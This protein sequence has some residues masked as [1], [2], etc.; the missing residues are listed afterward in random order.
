[1]AA[2]KAA[3]GVVFDSLMTLRLERSPAGRNEVCAALPDRDD[4]LDPEEVT[5]IAVA[6]NRIPIATTARR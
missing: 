5:A 3:S 4:T 1:M 2:V 6:Q